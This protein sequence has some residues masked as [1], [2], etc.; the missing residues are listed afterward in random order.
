VAFADSTNLALGHAVRQYPSFQAAADEAA[1]S[2][3][4]GGLHYEVDNVESQVLGRCIGDKVL[5]R[6]RIGDRPPSP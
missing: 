6:L 4:L 2:R 3:L 5:E 1:L